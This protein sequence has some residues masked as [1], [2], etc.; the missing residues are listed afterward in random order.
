[1]LVNRYFGSK[2]KLFAEVVDA[3]FAPPTIVDDGPGSLSARMA[4]ALV[5]RTSPEADAL[6][7]FLIML[8]SAASPVA[9]EIVRDGIERHVGA[10]LNGLLEGVDTQLRSEL[11]LSLIA[12]TWLLRRVIATDALAG[13]DPDDLREHLTRVF[14]VLV[15]A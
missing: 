5:G 10:R 12:G 4:D 6:G 9:A 11:L 15:K 3:A 1:M 2:E 7:P 8:R 13:A 14:D